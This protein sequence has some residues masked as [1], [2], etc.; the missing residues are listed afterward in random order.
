MNKLLLAVPLFAWTTIAVAQQG[1]Q[2]TAKDYEHAESFLNYNTEQLIDHNSVHPEWLPGDKFWYRTLTAQGSEF[3]LVDPAKKLR[4]AAF[5]QQKLAASLS[6]ATG[7]QYEAAMLPFQHFSYSTDEKSI[8][9]EANGKQWRCDLQ[10]YKCTEDNSTPV[11][12]TTRA[13]GR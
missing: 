2:L 9:F 3:I 1:V 8:I 11:K 7:K 4:T 12:K 13:Q 5:D 10:T 6:A